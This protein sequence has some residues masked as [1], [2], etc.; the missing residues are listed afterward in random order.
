MGSLISWIR[1]GM[2]VNMST[3]FPSAHR[4]KSIDRVGWLVE[5]LS[6]DIMDGALRPGEK[7]NEPKLS[8][9]FG[10]SRA[11]LREAIGRLEGQRLVVRTPRQGV[12]VAALALEECVKLFHV[13]E[14]LESISARLAAPVITARDISVLESIHSALCVRNVPDDDAL[15]LDMKFHRTIAAAS[16]ST[17]LS[18]ILSQEFYVFYKMMRR[19]HRGD[20]DR[21]EAANREHGAIISA[22]KTKDSDLAEF[23]MRR[24]VSGARRSFEMAVELGMVLPGPTERRG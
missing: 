6:Q 18:G 17:F 11:P 4:T 12:R 5:R 24:H 16:G 19:R 7:L 9:R 20:H 13:R 23:L 15:E 14:G 21:Q 2:R 3:E 8:H 1:S 10:V 22:L